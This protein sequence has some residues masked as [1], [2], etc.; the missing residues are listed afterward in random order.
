MTG[1]SKEPAFSAN[2]WGDIIT[3]LAIPLIGM[4]NGGEELPSGTAFFIAPWFA[5]TASHVILDYM[6][7]YDGRKAPQGE[8]PSTFE[9]VS[10]QVLNAGNTLLPLRVHR[11]WFSEPLDIAFLHVV[12]AAECDPN[13]RW[14]VPILD[15]LP[16]ER[17]E[18][19]SAFGYPRSVIT[20]NSSGKRVLAQRPSTA[21]GEVTELHL[22]H[23]DRAMMPYPCFRTNS[24]FVGGMSGG[25]VL[26]EWGAICGVVC[27]SIDFAE[28]DGAHVSYASTLWPCMGTMV[29]M[30][31]EE[32]YP[33]GTYFPV[34][35]L[36][37]AGLIAARNADRI[38]LSM[39]ANGKRIV[40]VYDD[41]GDRLG[42]ETVSPAV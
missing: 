19:V 16:P 39:D 21:V 2:Q 31:W 15:L 12:P 17:G 34:I 23:R 3:E 13:R 6:L 30:D 42:T 14:I 36:V 5:I 38:R 20:N 1:Y 25:P 37:Q 35:E 24:R 22:E 41:R 10:F 29:D 4:K 8:L 11:V 7:R 18:R 32:R 40:A 26:N 27:S 9:L 33:R 28:S